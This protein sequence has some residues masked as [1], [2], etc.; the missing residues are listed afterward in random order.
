MIKAVYTGKDGSMGFVK[1][2]EYTLETDITRVEMFRKNGWLWIKHVHGRLAD[3]F[4]K[5]RVPYGSLETF[6][7]NWHVTSYFALEPYEHDYS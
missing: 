6:L 7:A 5:P 4:C 2:E 1:G 3:G